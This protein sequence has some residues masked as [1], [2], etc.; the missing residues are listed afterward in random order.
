MTN[1]LLDSAITYISS[2]E[3]EKRKKDE[4]M[5]LDDFKIRERERLESDDGSPEN[6]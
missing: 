6:K 1:T 3:I 5:N 4:L 2:Y